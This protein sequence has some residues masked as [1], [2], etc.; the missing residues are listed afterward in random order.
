EDVAFKGGYRVLVCSTDESAD[1]QEA[2]LQ[3][4]EEERV[5]G[6][7]L[8]PSDPSGPGIGVLI[9][10]GIPVV[11]LDRAVRDARADAVL[12]DN[13]SGARTATEVLIAAG[14]RDI[15]ILAGPQSIDTGSERRAG[16]EMAMRGAG[17]EPRVI[18]GGFRTEIA[19]DAV[20]HALGEP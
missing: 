9:D 19:R 16:Y 4:L 15:A 20:A 13:L 11:A 8:S 17:L 6:V 7:I 2:Y 1:K 5:L 3:A 18:E 10:A 14:H 12:P